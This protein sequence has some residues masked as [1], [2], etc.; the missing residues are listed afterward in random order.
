[1]KKKT[2][3]KIR[4][5]APRSRAPLGLQAIFAAMQPFDFQCVY[6]FTTPDAFVDVHRAINR[7]KQE[8]NSNA[9]KTALAA[10]ADREY[11]GT[12]GPEEDQT[13]SECGDVAIVAGFWSGVAACWYYM[14]AISGKDG[15]Q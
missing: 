11:P 1:M 15:S 2:V 7:T 13:A 5:P 9:F 3:R 4:K 14:N 8:T 6:G 10:A 12:W